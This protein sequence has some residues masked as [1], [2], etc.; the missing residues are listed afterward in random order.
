MDDRLVDSVI[1]Y[2]FESERNVKSQSV[3]K[4][5]VNLAKRAFKD[6]WNFREIYGMSIWRMLWMRACWVVQNKKG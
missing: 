6:R 5:R 1:S 2:V 3:W 4:H